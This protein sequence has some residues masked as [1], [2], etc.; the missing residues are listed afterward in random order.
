MRSTV[1]VLFFMFIY[2]L[3]CPYAKNVKV[4]MRT[5]HKVRIRAFE[6]LEYVLF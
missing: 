6:M 5:Y 3:L 1:Y 2:V 4:R